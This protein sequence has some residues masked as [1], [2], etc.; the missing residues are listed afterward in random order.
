MIAIGMMRDEADIIGRTVAHLI[1]QGCRVV[2]ADNLSVDGS[3]AIAWH[4]GADVVR[5]PDPAH[6][7]SQKMTALA[8]R[9]AKEGEWVV[10]FDADEQWDGLADLHDDY[11]VAVAHPVVQIPTATGWR[12]GPTETW[13]KVA[14]RWRPGCRIDHGNHIVFGAGPR[15]AE[16]VV[17]VKHFQYR[18]FEQVK[19]KV[20]QG[21]RALIAAGLPADTGQH[22]RDLARLTDAELEAWWVDYCRP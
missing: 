11:D 22:W 12:D 2:V 6:Y 21:A 7:Q 18:T 13:P 16:D 5:D 17:T 15:I 14:F 20:R 1:A 4:A 10:P 3:D 9:H 8:A 19:R